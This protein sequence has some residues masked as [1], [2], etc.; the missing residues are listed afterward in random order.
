M[1]PERSASPPEGITAHD[2]S[3]VVAF[4]MRGILDQLHPAWA[5]L[6]R[7]FGPKLGQERGWGEEA[8]FFAGN[9]KNS[10]F[11]KEYE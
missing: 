9:E 8:C 10:T 2:D 6:S 11:Q 7:T 5:V 3:V 1:E 4:S